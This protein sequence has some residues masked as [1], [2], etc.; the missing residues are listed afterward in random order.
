M[1]HDILHV[2]PFHLFF[3][4]RVLVINFSL[5]IYNG[6]SQLC[7]GLFGLLLQCL[8]SF[9]YPEIITCLLAFLHIHCV[10]EE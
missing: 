10:V 2:T 3:P 8:L 6:H 9:I 4:Q 5:I 7:V 1:L